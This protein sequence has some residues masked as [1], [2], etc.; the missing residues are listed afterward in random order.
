MSNKL[1][2]LGQGIKHPKEYWNCVNNIS[3]EFNGHSKK[4]SEPLFRNENGLLCSNPKVNARTM[5]EHFQ[6]VNNFQNQLDP[7][8]FDSVRQKPIR[9]ELDA[10]PTLEEGSEALKSAKKGKAPGDSK[11]SEEFWQAL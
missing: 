8:V 9:F 6:K 7:T 2:G 5:K 11:I 1:E 3:L 4:V 10:P